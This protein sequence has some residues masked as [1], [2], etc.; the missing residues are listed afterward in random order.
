[1][2]IAAWVLSVVIVINNAHRYVEIGVSTV[3]TYV[4]ARFGENT[5]L[6]ISPVCLRCWCCRGARLYHCDGSGAAINE[7][8]RDLD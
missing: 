8:D 7:V 3:H 4:K 1:M 6:F 5:L 2:P